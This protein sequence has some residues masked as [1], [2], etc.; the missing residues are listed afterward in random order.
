MID[1]TQRL[2]PYEI[3]L[4][5]GL[6]VTVKPLTTAGMADQALC[7]MESFHLFPAAAEPAVPGMRWAGR[8][9]LPPRQRR[10]RLTSLGGTR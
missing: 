10:A 7:I 9:P 6:S 5:Y 8:Q 4:P 1:L 2:E 3:A